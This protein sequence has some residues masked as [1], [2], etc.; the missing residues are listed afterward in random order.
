MS[1]TEKWSKGERRK[2]WFGL[3]F[4]EERRGEK[5]KKKTEERRKEKRRK[6]TEKRRRGQKRKERLGLVIC[7]TGK[8]VGA[9]K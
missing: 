5:K 9:R 2:I 7:L 4:Y 1:E 8:G 6:R 3:F